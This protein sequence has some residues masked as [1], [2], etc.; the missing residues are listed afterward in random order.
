MAR[1]KSQGACSRSAAVGAIDIKA[2][3]GRSD[4]I[5]AQRTNCSYVINAAV[6]RP[7]GG[8]CKTS[9]GRACFVVTSLLDASAF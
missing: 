2:R 3:Q 4:A 6:S 8:G 7:R 9:Q 1:L 5:I